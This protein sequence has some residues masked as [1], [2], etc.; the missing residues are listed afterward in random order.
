MTSLDSLYSAAQVRQLD[1]IAIDK[2]DLSAI[3]LMKRAGRAAF[4][5]LLAQWPAVTTIHVI[6]GSGNNGG[7]GY[8]LAALAVQRGLSVTVWQLSSKLTET[9]ELAQNYALQQG[10]LIT[11]FDAERLKT[12]ISGRLSTVTVSNNRNSHSVSVGDSVATEVLVDA[13]LGTGVNGELR[14]S[15][16]DAVSIINQSSWPVLSLDIPSGVNPDNG[17]V[18]SMAVKACSTISFIGQKIGNFVG[19]GRLHSGERFF[20][21]LSVP[22][23]I[24]ASLGTQPLSACLTLSAFLPCIPQRALDAHKKDSGHL[25]VVG[26]DHGYGGAPLMAAEMAARAGAG[27]VSVVTQPVNIAAI[28]ARRPELMALGVLS[29]QEC[30][31]FLDRS[32]VLAIGSGLGQSAWSEQLLYHCLNA[33]KPM[34]LDADALNLMAT[35]RFKLSSEHIITPHPGEAARLLGCSV[36]DIQS[37]RV[38][39]VTALQQTFGGAV[40]LKGAGTLVMTSVQQLYVCDAGNPAMASAG[41]GDVLCGLLGALLAQGLSIDDAACLGTLLH[42]MAADA[43]VSE[44]CGYG[45]LATDLIGHVRQLLGRASAKR[46]GYGRHV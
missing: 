46:C 39:A 34:V 31:P 30:L 21:D 18:A 36:A 8:V 6:C 9:A 44:G 14:P 19:Q 17:A 40:V 33:G 35:G 43:A 5:H 13:L 7:D 45:L 22:S 3:V 2:H 23:E 11:P 15:Y 37:D 28:T 10:V 29:G 27:L 1:R 25:L 26:G 32:T 12:V 4:R 24:Y 42:S 41:M 20:D 38:N 16:I